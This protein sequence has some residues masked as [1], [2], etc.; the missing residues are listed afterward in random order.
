V[1]TMTLASPS[2]LMGTQSRMVQPFFYGTVTLESKDSK[3]N[4]ARTNPHSSI[5]NKSYESLLLNHCCRRRRRRRPRSWRILY[6]VHWHGV[7]LFPTDHAQSCIAFAPARMSRGFFSRLPSFTLFRHACML[8]DHDGS[9]LLDQ[10]R[11]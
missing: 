4:T 7:G 6:I 1:A 8:I 3:T 9:V 11:E 2:F 5:P 10:H